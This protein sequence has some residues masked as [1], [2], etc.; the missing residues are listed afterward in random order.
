MKP[1]NLQQKNYRAERKEY[2]LVLPMDYEVIIPEDDSVKLLS[3]IIEGMDLTELYKAYSDKGR[4][5]ATEPKNQFKI[6]VYAYME[7]IYSTRKIEKASKRD[8]NFMWLLG[9]DAAPDHTTINRFRKERVSKIIEGLFYQFVKILCELGEVKYENVFDD[10]TKIEA[11]ANRYTFVWKKAV[12]KN[13]I[14]MHERSN[15][16]AEEINKRY[17][18]D[19]RVKA[20]TADADMYKMITFLET[21]M[22]E[23]R[24]E[25]VSGKGKRKSNEQKLME[26]LCDYR[27]RQ[28]K[29]EASKEIFEGRNSYSK[30]DNDATFM[31]MKDDHM[32]NGQLKPGYNVQLAVENE[33]VIGAGVFP[34][35]TD[36]CTLKPL[37]ER[38]YLYNPEMRILRLIADSGYESEENY[39]YLEKKGI[40][41]YI[42]PQNYEQQKKRSYKN[43]ISKRENMAYNPETDEYTCANGKQLKPIRMQKSKTGSGYETELTV[44]ECEN[45]G[46]C[47]FKNKCTK[48]KGNR[49]I[50][51]S[52]TFIA[53]RA[54]SL[55]NISTQEGAI[56]RM[57]RSIQSEGAFGVLKQDRQFTRFLT[58]GKANVETE[59]FLLCFGYNVNK[60][61][62]KI[63]SGRC[64]KGLHQPK[65]KTA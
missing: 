44:Y 31:R 61:H 12:E 27:E 13:E 7:G 40:T 43:D 56:L 14:K 57:N 45:C 42:K 50:K 39:L 23:Q 25:T 59:I 3:Q 34:N 32:Q 46:D 37:L 65:P 35:C 38:M 19:F 24:I 63:Q 22:V 52:K 8:I 64:G 54:Q 48:A 36:V 16:A 62:A 55:E 17:F 58:R 21:K 26:S 51:V 60:L 4:K 41:Y 30:T 2:Q 47:P 1:I 53:K 15:L 20:E 11:N 49:Q 9:G 10:G 28:L 18:T 5:P 6:M 33:Y 29:Y